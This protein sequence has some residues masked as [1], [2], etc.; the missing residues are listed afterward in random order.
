MPS[1][2]STLF[3]NAPRGFFGK[4]HPMFVVYHG[5]STEVLQGSRP[6]RFCNGVYVFD[7]SYDQI[8]DRYLDQLLFKRQ[9]N[10]AAIEMGIGKSSSG[11][12]AF[13]HLAAILETISDTKPDREE[14]PYGLSPALN[15]E[16]RDLE[17][18][19]SIEHAERVIRMQY[20]IEASQ[21]KPLRP[22][23]I[24]LLE[25]AIAG[26]DRSGYLAEDYDPQNHLAAMHLG[27]AALELLQPEL[28]DQIMQ[29]RR[30]KIGD[31]LAALG[32]DTGDF[33]SEFVLEVAEELDSA[34]A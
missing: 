25:A 33:R 26:P 20:D 21:V 15:H 7:C 4:P 23:E 8:D 18:G 2:D 29:G 11:G 1:K 9:V 32:V 17:V 22:F 31:V 13:K 28:L 27:Y 14:Y 12:S 10:H 34:E 19:I 6:N 24:S 3:I 30:V 5:T 16:N